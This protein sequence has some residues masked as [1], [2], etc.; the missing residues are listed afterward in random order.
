MSEE[1]IQ[2][3]SALNSKAALK[4]CIYRNTKSVFDELKVCAKEIAHDLTPEVVKKDKNLEVQYFEKSEFEFHLKFSGDTIAYIMHTNVFNFPPEHEVNKMPYIKEVPERS[5]SG[6]IQAYNFLSDSIKY[7]R[8]ADVGYLIARLFINSEGHF[9]VDGQ[10][11]LGF[12]FKDFAKNQIK[13]DAIVKIIEQSMLF[14]LDFD[15]YV[16]PMELMSQM[17]LQQK[18]Y[19]NN[20]VGFATGKRL[21]FKKQ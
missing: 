12:L 7:Q 6:M 16:P 17:T 11:Q 9:Y 15:L 20:P 10:R 8:L 13:K 19:M 14:A 5:Y 21:G 4:Q 2:I 1:I 18:N 3:I